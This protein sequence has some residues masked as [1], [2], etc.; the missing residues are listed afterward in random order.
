M[1]ILNNKWTLW[2][3]NQSNNWDI[4][5]YNNL[6]TFDTLDDAI[7]FNE[8][9]DPNIVKKSMMFLMKDNIKPIWE[10]ELNINGGSF[11]YKIN[12]EIVNNIW[13][14]LVYYLISMTIHNNENILNNINGISISPK[15]NFCIIKLWIANINNF[16]EKLYNDLINNIDIF[17]IH[18]LCNIEP[19]ICIFKK[20]E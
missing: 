17:N 15:K 12:E 14:K 9:I 6:F 16:D 1:N 2:T 13:K 11:S 5:G 3:H 4:S 8:N 18:K 20:Y 10:D 19:Q 7:T